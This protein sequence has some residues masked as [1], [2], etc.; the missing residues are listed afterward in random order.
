MPGAAGYLGS[1]HRSGGADVDAIEHAALAVES[2]DSGGAGQCLKPFP[3]V[4]TRMA[5]RSHVTA[6]LH[7]VQ[8][9]L[10]RILKRLVELVL[11]APP[12]HERGFRGNGL[13]LR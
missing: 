13:H 9:S 11:R 6:G 3:P 4:A 5:M 2:Q 8:K 7:G 1:I 10:D 12:L